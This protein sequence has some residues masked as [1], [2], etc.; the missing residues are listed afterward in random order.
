METVRYKSSIPS[1]SYRFAEA[2]SSHNLGNIFDIGWKGNW[3]AIMG[4]EPWE[5]FIPI[6]P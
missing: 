3:K 4:D 6:I 5:W 2:P 1:Q